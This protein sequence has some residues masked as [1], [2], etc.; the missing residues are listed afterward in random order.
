MTP[1]Q[2]G[3]KEKLHEIARNRSASIACSTYDC[4]PNELIGHDVG[5]VYIKT[6]IKKNGL[7]II[8]YLYT[9]EASVK[10]EDNDI[11]FELPDYNKDENLLGKVLIDFIINSIDGEAYVKALEKARNQNG[12]TS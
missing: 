10:I 7:K 8:A 11:M 4:E 12:L 5:D 9:D 3:L 2:E 1:F 6:S